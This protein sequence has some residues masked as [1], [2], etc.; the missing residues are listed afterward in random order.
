MLKI[1]LTSEEQLLLEKLRLK[2]SSSQRERAWYVLLLSAGKTISEIA[3]ETGRN[4]HTI[5][6]WLKRYLSAGIEGLKTRKPPGRPG[7]LASAIE[8]QLDSLLS[9]SPQAYGYQSC[10]WQINLLKNHFNQQGIKACDNTIRTALHKKGYVFKRFA[11]RVPDGI[12]S[13]QEKKGRIH[14]MVDTIKQLDA[15]E[16]EVFFADESHFS[17]QP[18][19][20]RGWFKKG[21]K[22]QQ[23]R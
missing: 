16:V 8:L 15:P 23:R 18:Y 10:G 7:Q 14:K 17:N 11:K 5:R 4:A 3:C 2:R 13:P 19:V 12:L 9:K 20:S 1:R 6:L 21:I 22:K